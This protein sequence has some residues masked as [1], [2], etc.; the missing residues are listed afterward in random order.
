[1]PCDRLETAHYIH[2]QSALVVRSFFRIAAAVGNDVIVG[3]DAHRPDFLS[4]VTTQ[5]TVRAFAE[6]LGCH[7]V[8]TVTL[9]RI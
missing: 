2:R 9:R 7:I 8:D 1:M 6:D 4:D 5:K 3:C